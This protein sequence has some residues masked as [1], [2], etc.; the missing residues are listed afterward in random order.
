MN[1]P[2]WFRVEELFHQAMAIPP[3]RRR[4][5]LELQCPNEPRIL[6]AVLKLI[7]VSPVADQRFEQPIDPPAFLLDPKSPSPSVSSLQGAML[8]PW[9]LLKPLAAGGMGAVWIA[10]RADGQFTMAAAVKLLRRG[11]DTE[12]ARRR[13]MAERQILASLQHP[14]IARLLDGG[15][16]PDGLPYLVM[17][18]IDGRPLDAH[19]AALRLDVQARLGLFRK[20]C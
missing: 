18:L 14:S 16:S 10:E 6:D 2:R 1:D 11:F 19:C 20:V 17:E 12:D 13:F 3:E 5:F 15:I 9:R 7:T 8:G 4:Q